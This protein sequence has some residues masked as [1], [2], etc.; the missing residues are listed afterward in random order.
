MSTRAILAATRL[1]RRRLVKLRAPRAADMMLQSWLVLVVFVRFAV[2]CAAAARELARGGAIDSS[3]ETA[4]GRAL[5]AR[6]RGATLVSGELRRM[7]FSGVGAAAVVTGFGGAAWLAAAAEPVAGIPLLA[8][9]ILLAAGP[10]TA[11]NIFGADGG[12]VRRYAL[13]GLPWHRIYVAKNAAWLAVM[14]AGCVPLLVAAVTRLG[15]AQALSVFAV[16]AF[17]LVASIAWGNLCS[18]VFAAPVARKRAPREGPPFVNQAAP[19]ALA[20]VVLGVHDMVA[21]FGTPGFIATVFCIAGA[22]AIMAGLYLR[23]VAHAFD[24]EV[25]GLLERLKT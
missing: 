15:A 2:N 17:G 12:A 6:G 24:R 9:F 7:A 25:E 8:G 20:A 14:G 1:S 19:F 23:R 10:G 3:T 18:L 16:F 13:A 22:A 5:R 11:A 4:P 21:P